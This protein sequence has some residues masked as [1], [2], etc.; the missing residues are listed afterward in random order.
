MKNEMRKSRYYLI[1]CVLGE[2]LLDEEGKVKDKILFTGS[3]E[4]VAEKLS[5]YLKGV[6]PEEV[7]ELISRNIAYLKDATVIVEEEEV[8]KGLIS[9]YP[10]LNVSVESP[11]PIAAEFRRNLNSYLNQTGIKPEDF[12]RTVRETASIFSKARV[13][14]AVRE[15]DLFIAQAISSLDETDKTI[16]LYASR[17]REWYSLHFP[18]LNEEVRDHKTYINIVYNIGKRDNFSVEKLM[19]LG[20]KRGRAERIVN[21]AKESIGADLAD[22]DMNVIRMVSSI[23]LKLYELRSELEKYIDEAMEDVA[24]NIKGLVGSLLGARLIALAGGLKRLATLPASTIQ[25]LG[26]EKALFRALRTGSKPPKHGV[27]FTYPA[28]FRS[29]RWQRGKIAR[30]LAAKLAIAARIDAF[31]GEYKADILKR[32]LENRIEEVKKLYAK[33]PPRRITREGFKRRRRRR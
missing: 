20:L 12:F 33:P 18:E 13:K 16:N 19:E 28:I 5:N 11:C 24:P 6:I 10:N 31:T 23:A 2:F 1:D 32:E 22:F 14:E 8:A 21:L 27:I 9:Q 26:A 17:I 29:P 15:R 7:K 25:V 3:P 4:E 30:A